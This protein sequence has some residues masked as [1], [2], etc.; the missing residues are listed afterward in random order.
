M[1]KAEGPPTRAQRFA[2]IVVPALRRAGYTGHGSN[3]KLARDTGIPESTVSRMLNGKM[4]PDPGSFQALGKII[5]MT[6]MEL[7]VAAEYISADVLTES[8]TTQ[9][10]S[11]T[12]TVEDAADT[13]GIRP[14]PLSREMFA[15]MVE[16]LRHEE[17]QNP[18]TDEQGGEGMAVER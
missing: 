12:T 2:A 7:M 4:I 13:L 3:A 5:N 8:G 16:R 9:V 15:A 10:R 1:Q 6:A 11:Q 14:D 18:D 17:G